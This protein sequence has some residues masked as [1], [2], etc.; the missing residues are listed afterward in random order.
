MR[1]TGHMCHRPPLSSRSSLSINK[2]VSE[3][4]GNGGAVRGRWQATAHQQGQQSRPKLGGSRMSTEWAELAERK[5]RS[6]VRSPLR[7][8]VDWRFQ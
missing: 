1:R 8:C 7:W 5:A 3:Q 2:E 6:P 4:H